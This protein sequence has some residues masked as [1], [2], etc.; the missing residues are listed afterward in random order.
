MRFLRAAVHLRRLKRQPKVAANLARVRQGLPYAGSLILNAGLI[1]VLALGYASFVAK[2]IPGAGLG[3]RV[4]TVQFFDT[5]ETEEQTPEIQ[6]EEVDEPEEAEVGTETVPEGNDIEAG[7]DA[8]ELEGDQAPE[9]D[10]GEQITASQ[11]GVSIPSIALPEV[12]AGAGRP[13][14][15]VGVDC[16]RIFSHNREQAL[17]CAGRE[18]LSGWRAEIANLGEDWDRFAEELGTERRQIRYGP[19]RGTVNPETFGYPSGLEVPREVREQYEAALADLRRRQRIQEF[20]RSRE[21][22]EAI[23]EERE[24]DQDAA[25]YN[26]VSPSGG[27]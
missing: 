5:P 11:L 8:G 19:L 21:V 3:E 25:T 4:I 1:L 22:E 13:D 2:G 18:I 12:D 7:E 27:G 15:I 26:P 9:E 23:T 20:G 10:L 14:G 16:Y 24:R 17:E 6:A